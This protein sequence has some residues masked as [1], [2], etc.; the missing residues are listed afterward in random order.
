MSLDPDRIFLQ[1]S[2]RT[3]RVQYA[4]RGEKSMKFRYL[5]TTKESC[6]NLSFEV[7]QLLGFFICYKRINK[8]NNVI[9]SFVFTLRH[10]SVAGWS[11]NNYEFQTETVENA[12]LPSRG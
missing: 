8:R 1:L 12:K 11:F 7:L 5:H 10:S 6:G 4:Y 9:S 3:V 2:F